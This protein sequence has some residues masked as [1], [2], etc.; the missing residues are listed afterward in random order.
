MLQRLHHRCDTARYRADGLAAGAC[1]W[2]GGARRRRV[3]LL[4][5]FSLLLGLAAYACN[6][7]KWLDH[8]VLQGGQAPA[9]AAAS[10]QAQA[11]ADKPAAL[12]DAQHQ[13]VHTVDHGQPPLLTSLPPAFGESPSR[14]APSAAYPLA[15]SPASGEPPFR[16]PRQLSRC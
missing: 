14:A 3:A 2:C 9:L 11:A 7:A 4:M 12:N 15:L 1:A 6:Y 16:P 8:E 13:L 10:V 5:L